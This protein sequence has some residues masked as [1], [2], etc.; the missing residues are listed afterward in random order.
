MLVTNADCIPN[1]PTY[2]T[3][4]AGGELGQSVSFKRRGSDETAVA[5]SFDLFG[6][7]VAVERPSDPADA[8]AHTLYQREVAVPDDWTAAYREPHAEYDPGRET[9][10]SEHVHAALASRDVEAEARVVREAVRAAFDRPVTTRPGAQ[11]AVDAAADHGTVGVLSNCSV[12]GLV[13]RTLERSALGKADFDAV[14]ASVDCGWRKPDPQAFEAIA[15]A[16]DASVADLVHVGDDPDTDGGADEAGGRS[17]V[18]SA[19]PLPDVPARLE[20]IVS[21]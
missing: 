8:V 1:P 6:T 11:S 3:G 13:E 9:P 15:A 10:L 2:S 21:R 12:H 14:V 5:V 16:L 4:V 18:L 17:L 7:L 20:A 19:T